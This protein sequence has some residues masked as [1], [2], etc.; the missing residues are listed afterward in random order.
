MIIK[1][2]LRELEL[3]ELQLLHDFMSNDIGGCEEPTS[4]TGLLVCDRCDFELYLVV[5]NMR[6]CNAGRTTGKSRLYVVMGKDCAGK[7]NF[8]VSGSGGL[9]GIDI[10]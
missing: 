10:R 4:T 8:G 6:N 5:E 7:L 2:H 1:G 3:L 9:P